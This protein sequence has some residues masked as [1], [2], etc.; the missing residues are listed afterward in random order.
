VFDAI[1]ARV[2]RHA[3]LELLGGKVNAGGGELRQLSGSDYGL[4]TSVM[5][6]Q[7]APGNGPRRHRHPHAEI[8]VLHDGRGRFEVEGTHFDAEAGDVV[9]VPPD[10]WHSFVNTG[11]GPLRQT[12]I[13]ENP[14]AVTLFEDGTRR[15]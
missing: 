11:S 15:D 14:R 10:V 9:I 6:A 4:T 7:V 1:Q 3:D 8:F 12:A 13:H 2:I 5:H